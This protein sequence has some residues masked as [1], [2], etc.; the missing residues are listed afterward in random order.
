MRVL[1]ETMDKRIN[2][3][4]L[5]VEA[6]F[7]EYLNFARRIIT[8]NELQRKRVRTSK[9]VYSLLRTDLE[10]GCIIPPLVLAITDGIE[11]KGDT[12]E[13]K[14]EDLLKK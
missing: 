9:T 3:K 11:L 13:E 14:G 4:N 8:N 6:T 2:S 12:P 7:E 1:S 10:Q 5:F